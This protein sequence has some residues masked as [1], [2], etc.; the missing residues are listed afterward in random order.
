MELFEFLQQVKAD[1]RENIDHKLLEDSNAYPFEETA[2]TEVIMQHLAEYGISHDPIPLHI[3]KKVGNA[4]LKLSGYAINDETDQ[5]DLF[6]SLYDQCDS[7]VQRP[8]IDAKKS[9]EQCLRFLSECIENDFANKIDKSDLAHGI[10]HLLKDVYAKLDQIRIIILTDSVIKSKTKRFQDRI[11]SG[12]VIKLEIMDIERLYRHWSEGKPR[13]EIIINFP[14]VSGTSLPCVYIPGSSGEFDY[15]LTAIP[16]KALR[17]IYEKYGPR[18]LEANV[19]SFLSLT[20]KVNKGIRETIKNCPEKFIAYNNGIVITTDEL[21]LTSLPSGGSAI[22]GL[23]G[24][25][26]VN[27]GQTTATIYFSCRK[28]PDISLERVYVPAKIV[29][30]KKNDSDSEDDLIADI[31]RYANSQTAVK[32][33]DLS[34]NKSYHIE[35]ER[36]SKNIYCPDGVS[37]WFYERASG[38]FKTLLLRDGTTPAK[39]KVLKD[40]FPPQR[41]I[42][43]TELAKYIIAWDQMPHQVSNGNQ[44]N[45]EK[46]MSSVEDFVPDVSYYKEC[47]AKA[48]IYRNIEQSIRRSNI[49]AFQANIAAYTASLISLKFSVDFNLQDIWNKQG[50]NNNC[51]S[52]IEELIYRVEKMLQESAKGKMISEWSKKVECW[53]AL[54]TI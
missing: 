9:A 37:R 50:I 21:S 16:G 29:V 47:I 7:I 24:M 34:A 28:E 53:D 8:E 14:E 19:R 31:S 42:T 5:L 11:I 36:H 3:V 1:I 26:I 32:V 44:K 54:R 46:F 27:G 30:L 25:Q 12:K 22:L 48:I 10:I 51:K 35:L 13:D 52:T 39:L 20:G 2:F 18:L 17:F 40:S 6:V 23:K 33:S 4:T 15:A 45:F 41:R 49:I 43:K 38:S